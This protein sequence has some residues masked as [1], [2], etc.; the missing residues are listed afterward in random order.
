MKAM[1]W[2]FAGMIGGLIGAAIWAGTVY[3]SGWEIGIVAWIIGVF[4]G[5]GVRSAAGRVTGAGPA[6][7]ALLLGISMSRAD[8][9]RTPT[10]ETPPPGRCNKSII[11]HLYTKP[12]D[13]PA[14]QY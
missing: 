9:A 2:I 3:F 4:A 6:V 11:R 5:I 12:R 10:P 8:A 14:R 7:V 1:S 13:L